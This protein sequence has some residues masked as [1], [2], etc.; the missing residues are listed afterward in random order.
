AEV[1]IPYPEGFLFPAPDL[2]TGFTIVPASALD[3]FLW[4][5]AI[6]DDHDPQAVKRGEA[7]RVRAS[8]GEEFSYRYSIAADPAR[9]APYFEYTNHSQQGTFRLHTLAWVSFTNSLGAQTPSGEYDTV[10]FTGY[11]VWN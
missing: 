1:H 7:K 8:N 10:T 5:R 2:A 9:E 4:M 6:Q 3:P 11:G